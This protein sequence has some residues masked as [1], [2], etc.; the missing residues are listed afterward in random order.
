MG[1]HRASCYGLLISFLLLRY[2]T[3]L[4]EGGRIAYK[5]DFTLAHI[6]LY[7]VHINKAAFGYS[8]C[9]AANI[10]GQNNHRKDKNGGEHGCNG[11]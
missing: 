5:N 2:H 10:I 3:K 4:A 11:R 6:V 1:F 9:E 7:C 8:G